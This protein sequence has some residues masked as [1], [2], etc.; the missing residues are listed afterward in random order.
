MVG[1]PLN[2]QS[3]WKL[4]S[5]QHADRASLPHYMRQENVWDYDQLNTV[6][7]LWTRSPKEV[8]DEEY[9]AFYKDGF[10]QTEV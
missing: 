2:N 7:P 10:K 1:S 6:K 3:P 5:R 4:V 9:L 8:T